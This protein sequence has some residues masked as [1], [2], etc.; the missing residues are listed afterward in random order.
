M[1]PIGHAVAWALVTALLAGPLTVASSAQ[2]ASPDG[3]ITFA[4]RTSSD[5]HDV[6]VMNADGTDV[7]NVTNTP[8]VDETDPQWSPDGTRIAF[9]TTLPDPHNEGWWHDEIFVMDADGSNRTNV[10]NTP[11]RSESSPSWSPDGARM[12]FSAY[13]PG[14]VMET[15]SDIFTMNADGTNETRLTFEDYEEIT[16]AWS[17]RGDEI[18]FTAVRNGD[19]EIVKMS[20]DGTGEV[21]LTNNHPDDGASRQDWAPE[22]SPDGGKIAFMAATDSP[23]CGDWEIWVMNA[24]GT[25]QTNLTNDSAGDD[26]PSWSPDGTQIVFQSNRAT[27]WTTELYVVDVPATLEA[28]ASGR[29]ARVASSDTASAARRLTYGG[30]AAPDW[31][32]GGES[33]CTVHGTPDAET[34]TGTSG[35]D[36][37]CGGGGNDTIS[38]GRGADTILGGG[39]AD[40]IVGGRGGD[41]LEGGRGDDTLRSRDDV[42][43]NDAVDGGRGTDTARADA[44]DTVTSAR[45]I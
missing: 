28:A 37:I 21:N 7:V 8:D 31:H 22:W 23:C 1:K 30:G 5:S 26:Y 29:V 18:A 12:V 38:G 10:T 4:R 20:V 9:T 16:P 43:G 25:A 24:D 19:W 27:G 36:V 6:F 41:T 34:L 17:P 33:A 11:G 14:D 44:G 45:R 39:G 2:T 3:K 32:G 35:A 15:Q 40:T 13:V 42:S